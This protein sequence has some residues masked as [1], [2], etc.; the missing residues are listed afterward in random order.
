MIGKILSQ[1]AGSEGSVPVEIFTQAKAKEPPNDALPNF[2]ARYASIGNIG[3]FTK[4]QH[5]GKFI[6]EWERLLSESSRKP[7]TTDMSPA[8]SAFMAV[9]D[10]DELVRSS[11]VGRMHTF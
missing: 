9:K 2:L 1:V 6:K 10:E 4:E 11:P 8:V 7:A 5:S 3:T